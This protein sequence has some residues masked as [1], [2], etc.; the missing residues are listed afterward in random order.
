MPEAMGT[1]GHLAVTMADQL[2]AVGPLMKPPLFA[3]EALEDVRRLAGVLPLCSAG[4]FEC[5]LS[6]RDAR[7]DFHIFLP[8]GHVDAFDGHSSGNG[9]EVLRRCAAANRSPDSPL[10]GRVLNFVLEFDLD[11]SNGRLSA[12][13]FFAAL[14]RRMDGAREAVLSLG[15]PALRGALV[16]CFHSLPSEAVI[17]HVGLMTSRAEAAMRLNLGRV[18][19]EHLQ[20]YLAAIGWQGDID[21]AGA[22]ARELSPVTDSLDLALDVTAQ[23]PAQR[24]GMEC[25]LSAQPDDEPRWRSLLE[26]LLKKGLCSEEKAGALLRWPGVER[27]TNS[28]SWPANIS[29]ADRFLGSDALSCFVRRINHVKLIFA[30]G[31]LTE[32][33]AYLL[34]GHQWVD[35]AQ[36]SASPQLSRNRSTSSSIQHD[37]S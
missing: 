33:K 14:D 25:F 7:V 3:P 10:Y 13:C 29:L 17:N 26:T 34:F 16:R 32:A 31:R 24:L 18:I 19:P 1:T 22:V 28:T 9:W 37:N 36:I 12:P 8:P 4:G 2:G 11:A 15:D 20:E 23:G 5:R 27:R 35:R 21:A 30:A 6:P